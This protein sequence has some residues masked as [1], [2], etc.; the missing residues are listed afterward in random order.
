MSA[1][2]RSGERA[3][4]PALARALGRGLR[5]SL[6]LALFGAAGAAPV[7]EPEHP[8]LSPKGEQLQRIVQ[9]SR[10]DLGAWGRLADLCDL[11]GHRLAGS[12]ALDRA[13]EM[14][15][16]WLR[17][18]QQENVTTEPVLVPV[19]RRG[20]ESLSV[21]APEPR[22]LAL[23]GL[24]GTVG[25]PG[26]EAEVVVLRTFAEL[27]PAVK[28]KI[29]VFNSPMRTDLPAIAQ[30]GDAVAFRGQGASR[31]AAFGAVAVLVRSVTTRSLYTPHTGSLRYDPA[32]PQIPAAAITPEDA[33]WMERM[34]RRGQAPRVRLALGATTAPDVQ[35]HNVLGEL[36]GGKQANE[37]V[38]I[39]AHL[40]SWDVGQGAHDDGAGVV[41]VVEALRVLR[42]LG[43]TPRR[44]IRVVLFTN[45]ENGLRGGGAYAVAHGDEP[46]K[47]LLESDLGGGWPLSWSA[48]GSPAQLEWLRRAAAPIGL[49][50]EAGGGGADISPF[51]AKGALVIGLRPDDSHY[52]DVHHTWADTVD[53][54]D[55]VALAEGTAAVAALAWQLANAPD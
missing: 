51:E 48:G 55:P 30:Y 46:H 42:S 18:D 16:G 29:V 23:L 53:K 15:A 6:L 14:T 17:E 22:D 13:V 12:A 1:A 31:A 34:G 8:P 19:W 32:Q 43:V 2:R 33:D 47:A 40:D 54:V 26:L 10:S 52:F 25:T 37:I 21:I 4:A 5:L 41:E 45:E 39:G 24:G 27:S 35:S 9:I 44:T 50:V 49:P 3:I 20:V 7:A 11:V 38:V 36:R 28:G